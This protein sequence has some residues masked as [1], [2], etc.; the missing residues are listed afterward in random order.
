MNDLG[1]VPTLILWISV[2]LF[3]LWVGVTI[4]TVF[5]GFLIGYICKE[6]WVKYMFMTVIV[7]LNE[8]V[9]YLRYS[10]NYTEKSLMISAG[11]VTVLFSLL[12]KAAARYMGKNP[13][14]TNRN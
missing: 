1:L 6:S 3:F 14:I 5:G 10:E 9:L 11:I 7:I 12:G 2:P 8:V 4:I 13:V